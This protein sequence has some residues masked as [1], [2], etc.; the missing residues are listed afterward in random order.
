MQRR[1]NAGPSVAIGARRAPPRHGSRAT[2]DEPTEKSDSQIQRD[3]LTELTWDT[4]V[5]VTDVGIEVDGGLVTLTGTVDSWAARWAARDVAR[6]V[7]G[8]LGVANDVRVEL[9]AAHV[10]ADAEIARAVRLALEWDVL[11]PHER[12]RT[13]A[14]GGKV[15][16]EGAVSYW[17]QYDDDARCV[18]NLAGVREVENRLEVEPPTP[19]GPKAVREAIES[20]LERRAQHAADHVGLAVAADEVTLTGVVPTYEELSAVLQAA[21]GTPGVRAVENKRHVRP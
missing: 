5:K 6:R 13:T 21:R 17:S 7:V 9:P 15:A 19:L 1:G 16:L 3:V 10:R 18:R 8:V 14:S 12:I 20:T 2:T 4:R 11:V